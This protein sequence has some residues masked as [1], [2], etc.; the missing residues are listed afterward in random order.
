VRA[1]IQGVASLEVV[2]QEVRQVA[3]LPWLILWFRAA[4]SVLPWSKRF[5]LLQLAEVS[6]AHAEQ[7]LAV[8]RE[9]R[10]ET[11]LYLGR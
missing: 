8:A 6:Q 2:E 4:L 9:V 5:P 10:A 3:V 11:G 1:A 7:V